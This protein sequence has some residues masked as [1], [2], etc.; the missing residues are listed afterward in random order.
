MNTE[1]LPIEINV[2]DTINSISTGFQDFVQQLPFINRIISQERPRPM[3][4]Y[5]VFVPVQSLKLKQQQMNSQQGNNQ[6]YEPFDNF[7]NK[8]PAY[9]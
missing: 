8:F 1:W 7:A 3:H 4:Q 2:P 9:P 5:I 6:L